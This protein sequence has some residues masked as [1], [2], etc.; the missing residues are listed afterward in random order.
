MWQRP[1]HPV[2]AYSKQQCTR[3]AGAAASRALTPRP[4][5][6]HGAGRGRDAGARPQRRGAAERGD[7][8]SKGRVA[9]G[10]APPAKD[11]RRGGSRTGRRGRQAVGDNPARIVVA[12]A[13]A[14]AHAR[15]RLALALD[16][17]LDARAADAGVPS[18]WPSASLTPTASATTKSCHRRRRTRR[19][20]NA[21]SR[22]PRGMLARGGTGAA[23]V[24]GRRCACSQGFRQHIFFAHLRDETLQV[25]ALAMRECARPPAS[26][27]KG[28][29]RLPLAPCLRWP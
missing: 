26:P 21:L 3:A 22:C 1:L 8:A 18:A 9:A 13:R 4:R 19:R 10:Q 11:Q 12:P 16:T 27:R 17:R 14:H 5:G 29:R 6:G 7:A 23:R 2:R 20:S 24:S 28:A 15:G 25:A